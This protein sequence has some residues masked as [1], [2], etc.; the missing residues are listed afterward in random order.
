MRKISHAILKPFDFWRAGF[1]ALWHSSRLV[2]LFVR[3]FVEFFLAFFKVMKMVMK[4]TIMAMRMTWNFGE[5][6]VKLED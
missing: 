3:P 6:Y 5:T 4:M 2:L 1:K